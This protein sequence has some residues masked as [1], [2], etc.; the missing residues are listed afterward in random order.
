MKRDP[1]EERLRK[2]ISERDALKLAFDMVIVWAA[3]Y[4]HGR[5]TYA[6]STVRD[7]VRI[8][9]SVDPNWKPT[10]RVGLQPMKIPGHPI[11]TPE[12]DL[13][14]IFPSED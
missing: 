14:D 4:A 10:E 13:T 5:A 12:D 3:R 8:R 6:P 7:A 1:I 9:R 2:A 11:A